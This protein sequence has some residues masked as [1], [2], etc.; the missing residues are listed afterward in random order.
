M[1]HLISLREMNQNFSHYIKSIEIGD[2]IIITRYGKSI[3]RIISIPS[4]RTLT[5]KQQEART[6][7]LAMMKK[8]LPLGIGKLNRD[9]LHER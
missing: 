8:G 1:Q 5:P 2:E 7:L 3:A 6:R 4:Q 9:E